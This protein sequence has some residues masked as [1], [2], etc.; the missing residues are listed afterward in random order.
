MANAGIHH[1]SMANMHLLVLRFVCIRNSIEVAPLT[2]ALLKLTESQ[3]Q[4]SKTAE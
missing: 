1:S 2:R 4:V 3:A